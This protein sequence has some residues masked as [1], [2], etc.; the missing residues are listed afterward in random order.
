LEARFAAAGE[1]SASDLDLFVRGCGSLR[2]MLQTLGL[3]RR[4]KDV[5]GLSLGEVL[6]R[7]I[8][9]DRGA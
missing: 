9:H 6:R 4:A 5:T 3:Q 2:R 7:G 8:D 1:A